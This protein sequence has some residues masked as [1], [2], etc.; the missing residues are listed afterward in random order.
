MGR[1]QN[2]EARHLAA[3]Y[4]ANEPDQD[5]EFEQAWDRPPPKPQNLHSRRF[6]DSIFNA[7]L[8][9][10]SYNDTRTMSSRSAGADVSAAANRVRDEKIARRW[11][12]ITSKHFREQERQ[13]AYLK[14]Q[15][16][17]SETIKSRFD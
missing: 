1:R 10:L 12:Q 14:N 5:H 3:G 6:E 8:E 17:V 4:P 7:E 2:E 16:S 9:E 11:P 15:R 13:R